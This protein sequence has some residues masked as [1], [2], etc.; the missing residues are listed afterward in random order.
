MSKNDLIQSKYQLV[1]D[2]KLTDK[3][4]TD[5]NELFN[6]YY[7]LLREGL[8]TLTVQWL[9]YLS[10]PKNYVSVLRHLKRAGAAGTKITKSAAYRASI[11][12]TKFAEIIRYEIK[13]KHLQ[14]PSNMKRRITFYRRLAIKLLPDEYRDDINFQYMIFQIQEPSDVQ[15][16]LPFR[17]RLKGRWLTPINGYKWKCPN[18]KP[19]YLIRH[20][21][22]LPDGM[23]PGAA[24]LCRTKLPTGEY[25]YDFRLA[26]QKR[27]GKSYTE[28]HRSYL[29][30]LKLMEQ[31][32]IKI[33]RESEYY[34]SLYRE[35]G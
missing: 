6:Q 9:L 14:V 11:S 5:L 2:L 19:D 32:Y 15:V 29:G 35:R 18:L 28:F 8:I 10:I 26:F 34:R 31:H 17:C 24:F 30:T 22:S 3:D 16:R 1:L 13:K 23:E 20:A 33:Q 27:S 25:K 4:R 12:Y 7:L 21:E